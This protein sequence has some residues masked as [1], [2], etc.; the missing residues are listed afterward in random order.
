MKK[1]N[2]VRPKKYTKGSEE[3][4]AWLPVGTITEFDNGNQ[5]LELNNSS[6]Q[7]NIFPFEEKNKDSF[8]KKDGKVGVE[9]RGKE[10]NTDEIPF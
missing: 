7:F 5:I 6:E 9:D 2:V 3:K 1:F 10:I 8:V 4:T